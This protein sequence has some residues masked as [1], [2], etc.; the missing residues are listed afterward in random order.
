MNDHLSGTEAAEHLFHL[1]KDEVYRH[2]LYVLGNA[3]D[4]EDV[5]SEVFVRVLRSWTQFRND[6]NTRTWVWSILKNYLIDVIRKR[7]RMSK[8]RSLE[9]AMDLSE[10]FPDL[11]DK[12]FW[13]N[14]LKRLSLEQRQVIHLRCIEGLKGEEASRRLGWSPVKYRVVM[15]MAR[16]SLKCIMHEFEKALN[17]VKRSEEHEATH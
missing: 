4:A 3:D 8:H 9:A 7:K 13:E 2:A 1:Y 5:V 11:L 10:P 6:S 12:Q 17:D 15:H 14:N 16:K